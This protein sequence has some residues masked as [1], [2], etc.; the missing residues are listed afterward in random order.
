[1]G[2]GQ[3]QQTIVSEGIQ[4]DHL[5]KAAGSLWPLFP[6]IIYKPQA[7]KGYGVPGIVYQDLVLETDYPIP[8]PPGGQ[9]QNKPELRLLRIGQ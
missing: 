1:M 5:L 3:H 7:V 6:F 2:P 4:V 9:R 8:V